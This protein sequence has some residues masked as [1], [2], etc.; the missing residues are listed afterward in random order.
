MNGASC[1]RCTAVCMVVCFTHP[2]YTYPV[3]VNGRDVR[4]H[5]PERSGV[6]QGTPWRPLLLPV[7]SSIFERQAASSRS[8]SCRPW[9]R[10]RA[11]PRRQSIAAWVEGFDARPG[12]SGPTREADWRV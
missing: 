7:A 6:K 11:A 3:F 1:M 9:R 2:A 4:V 5:S 12:R 8:R 10:E